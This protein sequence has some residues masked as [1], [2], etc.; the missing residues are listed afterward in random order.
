MVGRSKQHQPQTAT[1]AVSPQFTLALLTTSSLLTS[2]AHVRN[3]DNLR[4]HTM[5][6]LPRHRTDDVCE[7]RRQIVNSPRSTTQAMARL[8]AAAQTTV[9]FR[10][11]ERSCEMFPAIDSS[12]ALAAWLVAGRATQRA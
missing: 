1:T 4:H 3:V 12:Q 10:R 11:R 7:E 9:C 2:P 5:R 6:N 8:A